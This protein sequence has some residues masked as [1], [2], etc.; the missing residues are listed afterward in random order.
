MDARAKTTV[1]GFTLVE[2][3][4]AML[5]LTLVILTGLTVFTGRV[6][7][8]RDAGEMA[9]AWQALANEAEAR[10]RAPIPDPGEEI[11]FL[12]DPAA[13][14]ALEGATGEITVENAGPNLRALQLR[15]AWHDGTRS[16][17]VIVYRAST[18]GG[19]LW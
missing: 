3:L 14:G 10:R 5:I 11:A 6:R 7:R 19:E 12:T 4:V 1:A 17:E 15:V 13:G 9:L 18:G 8:L 2:V 16:A